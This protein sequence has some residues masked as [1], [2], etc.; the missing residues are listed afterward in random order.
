MFS[1]ATLFLHLVAF[2]LEYDL[3]ALLVRGFVVPPGLV[4]RYDLFEV[5]QFAKL[6]ISHS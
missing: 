4:L 5:Y 2:L 6:G 1:S 3:I